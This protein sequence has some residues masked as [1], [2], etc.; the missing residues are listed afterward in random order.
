MISKVHYGIPKIIKRF[1]V[2]YCDVSRNKIHERK[3]KSNIY[4]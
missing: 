3:L 4:K 1:E 2:K